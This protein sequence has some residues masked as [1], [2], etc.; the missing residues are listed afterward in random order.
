MKKEVNTKGGVDN[1]NNELSELGVIK[2]TEI[3][4]FQARYSL[5]GIG[6]VGNIKSKK[7]ATKRQI[8]VYY[9]KINIWTLIDEIIKQK[10]AR[11]KSKIDFFL[12]QA[13]DGT[14]E[15]LVELSEGEFIYHHAEPYEGD[16]FSD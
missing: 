5:G 1:S 2:T 6:F 10:D 12:N 7:T 8:Q 13:I 3:K 14:D 15:L 9:L 11:S 16:C 4:P